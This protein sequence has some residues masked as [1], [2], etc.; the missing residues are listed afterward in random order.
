MYCFYFI[1][2]SIEEQKKIIQKKVSIYQLKILEYLQ[3]GQ[4]QEIIYQEKH[5]VEKNFIEISIS[6]NNGVMKAADSFDNQNIFQ[7]NINIHL[8]QFI[9]MYKHQ[10]FQNIVNFIQQIQTDL[11]F[12]YNVPI[13]IRRSLGFLYQ[14]YQKP[15]FSLALKI[16]QVDIGIMDVQ[17]KSGQM[18]VIRYLCSHYCRLKEVEV[19]NDFVVHNYQI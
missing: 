2:D 10:Q 1:K 13:E 12:Q 14:E 11:T 17:Q 18:L 19:E 15:L 6:Q 9:I 5:I 4:W 16:D 8:D 7:Q 3:H